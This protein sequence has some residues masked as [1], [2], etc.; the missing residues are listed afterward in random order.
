MRD[1]GVPNNL[2]VPENKYEISVK[3]IDPQ[4]SWSSLLSRYRTIYRGTFSKSRVL[5]ADDLEISEYFDAKWYLET[6]ADVADAG[7]DPLRHFLEYGEAEGRNPNS[8][9]PTAYYRDKYMRAESPDASPLRHFLRVGRALGLESSFRYLR[10]ISAH[11]QSFGLEIPELLRHI[12]VMP[13]RPLFLIYSESA[14]PSVIAK[15]RT[16]L[17]NQI[18]PDW[19][20]CDTR[21]AVAKRLCQSSER[22]PFLVWLRGVDA[23]H[24][25]AFYCFASA[26]NA[27]PEIDVI[28]GDEDE[29]SDRGDR[30]HPFFKPDWKSGLSRSCAISWAV[31][32]CIRGEIVERIFDE[33]QSVY[34]LVLR[35]TEI[36]SVSPTYA[37]FLFIGCAVSTG[38]S[39]RTRSPKRFAR[40]RDA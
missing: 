37:R 34:D 11:N 6:Y 7:V 17:H 31:E 21:D 22:P 26:I 38:R 39:R 18:Y 30:S 16:A 3:K 9:F 40:S 15:I 5:D 12:R 13:I 2:C 8:V 10:K 33:S 1:E 25:S 19:T 36:H 32:P 24:S 4:A 29:I 14:E 20:I 23:L 27:D 28:Y 35:A